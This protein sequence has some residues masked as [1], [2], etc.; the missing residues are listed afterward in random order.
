MVRT[1]AELTRPLGSHYRPL[2]QGPL[3][4]TGPGVRGPVTNAPMQWDEESHRL[5][6][7]ESQLSQSGVQRALERDFLQVDTAQY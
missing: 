4:F 1:L 3:L 5:W 6:E 7:P 2:R